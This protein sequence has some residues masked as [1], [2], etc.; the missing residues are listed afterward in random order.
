V[1]ASFVGWRSAMSAA[2]Y[3][4]DGFYRRSGAPAAGFRTAAHS[5]PMWGEAMFE[6]ASRVDAALDFPD[7]FDVVDI[8]AGGGELLGALAR[9]AP[10]RWVLCGVDVAP[11]PAGLP[12][13]VTWTTQPPE[14][15]SGL[16]LAVEYL[17][18]VPVDVAQRSTAGLRMVLVDGESGAERLGANVTGRDA[19]W[20][21]QWWTP[22]APGNRAEIGWPRDEAWRSLTASLSR[23]AALAVDYATRPDR[24]LAGTL[25]GY[26]HGRQVEAVPD[27]SCDL[28]AHVLFDSLVDDEDRLY[29][30]AVALLALGLDRQGRFAAD[31]SPS[32]PDPAADPAGYLTVLAR[33]GEAVDLLDPNGL[34]GFTWL[35]HCRGVPSP[36]EIA[37]ADDARDG[38]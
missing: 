34:G 32:R 37:A 22:A 6:L 36:V 29:P 7:R 3:G 20:L 25:T 1:E 31:A 23:G 38:E 24:H 11:R 16:L 18:V 19:E 12:S 15:V 5:S 14:H 13:R 2:L 26:R 27:G 10:D 28:T 17:D 30:Q 9:R 4:T 8:G 33:A 35:L 21:A